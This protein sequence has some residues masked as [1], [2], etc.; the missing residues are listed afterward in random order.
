[1]ENVSQRKLLLK[2]R[3]KGFGSQATIPQRYLKVHTGW[4][5]MSSVCRWSGPDQNTNN[6][7]ARLGSCANANCPHLSRVNCLA[8]SRW[9]LGLIRLGVRSGSRVLAGGE[10]TSNVAESSAGAFECKYQGGHY[11]DVASSALAMTRPQNWK[12]IVNKV[13]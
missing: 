9:P 11:E 6:K 7:S 3:T 10:A 5:E 2:L 12:T 13:W 4:G 8:S 1:M